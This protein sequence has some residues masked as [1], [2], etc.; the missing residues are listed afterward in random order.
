MAPE[1][2]FRYNN[3]SSKV[4][5]WAAGVIFL[6]LLGQRHPIFSLNS[7]S[8]IKN[9]YLQN[10]IPLACIFGSRNVKEIAYS[11]GYGCIIP[12]EFQKD[13]IPWMDVCEI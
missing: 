9:F 5:V 10:L 8:K 11:F 13:Q 12:E 6:S 3:Q 4:D 2:L 7:N 1:S